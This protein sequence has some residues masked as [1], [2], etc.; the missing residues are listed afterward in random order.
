MGIHFLR[1]TTRIIL[2][3]KLSGFA[4]IFTFSTHS[5]MVSVL[6]N[7]HVMQRHHKYEVMCELV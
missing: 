2:V 5:P 3:I 6:A 1:L 4:E 7:M